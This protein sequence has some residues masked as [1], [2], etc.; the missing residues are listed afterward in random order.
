MRKFLILLSVCMFLLTG[1]ISKS[2]TVEPPPVNPMYGF[3]GVL[4]TENGDNVNDTFVWV[5]STDRTFFPSSGEYAFFVFSSISKYF[6]AFKSTSGK[7]FSVYLDPA[8]TNFRAPEMIFYNNYPLMLDS[9]L[10]SYEKNALI[11]IY[12]K[13]I[14]KN[15]D[16][17]ITDADLNLSNPNLSDLFKLYNNILKD[18]AEISKDFSEI[19]YINLTNYSLTGSLIDSNYVSPVSYYA[20]FLFLLK[21]LL[22]NQVQNFTQCN[23]IFTKFRVNELNFTD[24]NMAVFGIYPDDIKALYILY[25]IYSKNETELAKFKDF[26]PDGQQGEFSLYIAGILKNMGYNGREY[27]Q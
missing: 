9:N 20:G 22:G 10:T 21:N 14:V 16:E 5:D 6:T 17:V 15:F 1:C 26:S 7:S 12:N 13:F 18:Y 3:S 2:K 24:H 23:Q 19:S 25:L 4:K 11:E 27:I 8:N